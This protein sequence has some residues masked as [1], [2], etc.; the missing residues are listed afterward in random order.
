MAG[1]GYGPRISEFGS[2]PTPQVEDAA[3]GTNRVKTISSYTEI[4]NCLS[5]DAD[6]PSA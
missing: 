5:F 4:S 6:T 2:R 1:L 3:E